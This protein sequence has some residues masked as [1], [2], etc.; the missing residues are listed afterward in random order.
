MRRPKVKL[1]S[2]V[3]IITVAEKCDVDLAAREIGLTASAVRKQIDAVEAILGVSLFEKNEGKLAPTEDGENFLADAKMAV[4]R[5]ILAEEKALAL[6]ALKH[7]H[8]RIGHST[9]LPP[10]MI[11]LI[12]GMK[13][14]ETPLVR[15]EHV[16]GLTME[17]VRRV[18]EGSLHAG[19][20][21]LPIERPELLC[22]SHL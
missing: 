16:S 9:Y 10:R 11:A 8:L 17:I 3:A 19:F 14:E 18:F 6:Q 7:H 21:F 1:D 20:G 2:L 4:E 13:L 15:I 22:L 12:N 5:A